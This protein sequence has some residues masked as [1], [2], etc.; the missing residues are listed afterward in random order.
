[1]FFPIFFFIVFAF[2]PETPTYLQRI[3]K[4]EVSVKMFVQYRN[5]WY[6]PLLLL[7]AGGQL[8][9]ILQRF[10]IPTRI[11][12]IDVQ[13]KTHRK[14]NETTAE[15]FQWTSRFSSRVHFACADR[16]ESIVR[17]LRHSRLFDESV[18]RCRLK[19]VAD[20]GFNMDLRCATGRFYDYNLPGRPSRPQ[21]L[22]HIV[23]SW[24]WHWPHRPW[25]ACHSQEQFAGPQ[26]DTGRYRCIDHIHCIAGTACVAIHHQHGSITAKGEPQPTTKCAC[27][28]INL[29]FSS[30]RFGM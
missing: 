29:L 7:S 17:L 28:A 22:V 24:C 13:R 11:G 26:L 14:R 5:Q 18:R 25:Y 6:P 10:E 9:A 27:N 8:A 4:T 3:N 16:F 30:P 19:F 21:N 2:V 23:V 12:Q 1:M 20:R 15:R